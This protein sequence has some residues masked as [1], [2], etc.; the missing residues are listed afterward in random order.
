G[1][2]GVLVPALQARGARVVRA[3]VYEREA[4]V[5]SRQAVERLLGWEGPAALAVSSAQALQQVLAC[6]PSPAL[7]RLRAARVVAAS[8]RLAVL[9]RESGFGDVAIAASARPADLVAAARTAI[10]PP[11]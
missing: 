9:A 3:D 1:G 11:A 5:P 4:V 7:A 10:A 8:E 2:R 6:L